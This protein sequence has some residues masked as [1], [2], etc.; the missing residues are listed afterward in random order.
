MASFHLGRSLPEL[1]REDTDSSHEYG[2]NS[3]DV[4]G[5]ESDEEI[6]VSQDRALELAL[7]IKGSTTLRRKARRKA[8][9]PEEAINDA[10]DMICEDKNYG[11]R[12]IFTNNQA[13]KTWKV[14]KR[15][16]HLLKVVCKTVSI[17]FI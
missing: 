11:R 5:E 12:L 9:W 10:V 15:L 2:G 14:M 4:D 1:T 3:I 8:I 17:C 7:E 6:D 13:S 16:L